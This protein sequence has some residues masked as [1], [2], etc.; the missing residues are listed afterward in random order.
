MYPA[1]AVLQ[2]I[3][4]DPETAQ[5]LEDILWVGGKSGMDE[6]I[7]IRAGLEYQT[8]PAAGLHGVGLR[9]LPGNLLQLLRGYWKS[10]KILRE[11]QPDVLFFTGGYL[12]VPVALA[13]RSIP[14]V[15]FVPDIEPGLA[16]KTIA[17]LADVIAATAEET[18]RYFPP[19]SRLEVTGYPVRTNLKQWKREE[20]LEAFHLSEKDPVLL[21][22]GG[23]KGA[24]SIN[25]ALV[26]ALP[27]LLRFTQVIHITGRLDWPV[28]EDTPENLSETL[29]DKLVDRYRNF[30]YLHRRMGAALTAADLV[31]SRA[32]ASILGEFTQ[33]EL[34]AVLVPYPHAWRYQQV[35]AQYLEDKGGAVIV[36]DQDLEVELLPRIKE[37]LMD[38][39]RLEEMRKEIK[40]AAQPGAAEKIAR[41]LLEVSG[42]SQREG[43]R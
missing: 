15:L 4:E 10:R 30:P 43:Q 36:Q 8:I 37:I 33:F 26:P 27:E 2:A 41:L 17:R 38:H 6:E 18:R 22:F 42:T 32:G 29:P 35:N 34:P 39:D 11:F 3:Q 28:L 9:K 21:V 24:R 25:Q 7:L 40:A 23:S 31:V 14:S 1:V 20:A 12:A 16:L 19:K 5:A 13:G